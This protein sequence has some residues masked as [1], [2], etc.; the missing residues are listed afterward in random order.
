MSRLEVMRKVVSRLVVLLGWIGFEWI[1]GLL[2]WIGR[3]G[4]CASLVCIREE[5]IPVCDDMSK[6][7]F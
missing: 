5:E 3:E 7:A 6:A 2:A 1:G 4:L